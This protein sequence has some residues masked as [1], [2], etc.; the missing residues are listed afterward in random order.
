MRILLSLSVHL[1]RTKDKNLWKIHFS[2]VPDDGDNVFEVFTYWHDYWSEANAV[3]GGS[4]H[5]SGWWHTR[6]K[7]VMEFLIIQICVSSKPK[8]RKRSKKKWT[9]FTHCVLIIVSSWR[10]TGLI[11]LR[12]FP[13][14]TRSLTSGNTASNQ[15][16]S[17]QRIYYGSRR[18]AWKKI[19]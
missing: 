19:N 13:G 12:A 15:M 1:V 5:F 6:K 3:E 8:K 14:S 18:P 4:H 2:P 16:L 9:S 11:T 17:Q 10:H 7:S